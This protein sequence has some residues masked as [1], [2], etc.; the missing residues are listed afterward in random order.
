MSLLDND[1]HEN[2]LHTATSK[3]LPVELTTLPSHDG[4][5]LHAMLMR[6]P[7][8]DATKR[9]P[10]IVLAPKGPREQIVRNA[11][12]NP[13]FSF[14]QRLAREGFVV[15]AADGR[16][17]GG[18]GRRFEEPIHY[19][20]G[21]MELTD[22]L[23][24]LSYLSRVSF[25]DMKRVGVYGTG[26]AG[27]LALGAM[28]H[29]HGMYR[30]GVADSPITDWYQVDV[31]T[32]ERYLGPSTEPAVSY[33]ESTPNEFAKKHEGH[34]LIT[35]DGTCTAAMAQVKPLREELEETHK[36]APNRAAIEVLGPATLF[37]RAARFFLETLAYL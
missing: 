15:F 16:G 37:D 18:R 29:A 21:G 26:Y 27:M 3:A 36:L 14:A 11:S 4:L 20:L 5:T 12:D 22:Q 28:M 9:Y 8:F 31:L 17:S 1:D 6:P 23:D 35:V 32:A 34:L 7:R 25:V 13:E 33:T 19:R 10:V 2:I 30:A 24:A